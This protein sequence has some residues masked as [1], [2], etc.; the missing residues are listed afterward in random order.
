[1]TDTDLLVTRYRKENRQELIG[2]IDASGYMSDFRAT[3]NERS[4]AEDK[5]DP[6]YEIFE[7]LVE[8]DDQILKDIFETDSDLFDTKITPWQEP[9][10]SHQEEEAALAR[11]E[12]KGFDLG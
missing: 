4:F 1:M 7:M 2:I 8:H 9:A 11:L 6:A 10:L 3:F 12:A 5:T